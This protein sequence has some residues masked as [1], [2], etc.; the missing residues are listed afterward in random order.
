ML[1]DNP[2]Y[3]KLIAKPNTWF[4]AGT[5]VFSYDLYGQRFTIEE[6][7]IWKISGNILARGIRVCQEKFELD[8]GYKIGE[9]REDGEFCNIDEFYVILSEESKTCQS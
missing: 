1:N 6:Y 4:K 2:Q 7:G 9:E 3:V 5:E 8:L